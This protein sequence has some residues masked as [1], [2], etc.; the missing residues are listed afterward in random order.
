M[1]L[2]GIETSCDET[3]AAVVL[4]GAA[5]LSNIVFSQIDLHRQF[6]GVVPEIASRSHVEQLPWVLGEAVREAG[7]GWAGIDAIGVTRGPGLSTSLLIGLAAAK[8]LAL[9]LGKPLVPVNHLEAHVHSVFLG[10][11]A[12][13]PEE[14]GSSVVLLA[15]GGHTCLLRGRGA[16]EI[17]LIGETLDDAAGEALDKGAHL[18]RLGYPGGPAIEKAAEGGDPARVRFPR[19]LD[20][21]TGAGLRGGLKGRYSF[22]F[23]GLKTALLYYVRRNPSLFDDGSLRHVAASYQEAVFDALVDRARNAMRDAG[24]DVLACVGGVSRNLRLR[25]KLEELAAALGVRLLLARP[26]F[27]TDNAAMVAG[28][29]HARALR[30]DFMELSADVDPNLE[31]GAGRRA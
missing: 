22:S 5:V 10:K 17:E 29:A 14:V 31:I 9:S 21:E 13:R 20:L 24:C 16:E 15:T 3:A 25:R 23:S 8:S 12:P 2:L 30:G 11:D 26:E 18:L 1:L 7:C 6:G 19:G 28:R 27:C 4:D